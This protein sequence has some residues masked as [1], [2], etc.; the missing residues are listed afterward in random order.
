ML[1]AY[2]RRG[3]AESNRQLDWAR[4]ARRRN[5]RADRFGQPL[6]NRAARDLRAE[7]AFANLVTRRE[8]DKDSLVARPIHGAGELA[9]RHITTTAT[10]SRAASCA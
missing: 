10:P 2:P 5:R 7:G 9:E 4:R 3:T 1:P 8:V 6:Y